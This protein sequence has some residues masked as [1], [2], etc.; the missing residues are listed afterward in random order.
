[1]VYCISDIRGD[2]DKFMEMFCKINLKRADTL[3][4]LGNIIDGKD[5]MKLLLDLMMRDNVYPIIGTHEYAALKC[6]SWLAEHPNP[7][8]LSG[9]DPDTMQKMADWISIGGQE[10][11]AQFRK[12]TDEEREMI[13]DYLSDFSLYEEVSAEGKDFVLVHAGINNFDPEKELDDYDIY[14]LI[15]ESP[16]F[17]KT[18]FENKYLV[19]GHTPTRRIYEEDNPLIDPMPEGEPSKYDKV[20]IK[21]N[22]IAINC[23]AD[24]GGRLAAVRLDDMKEFYVD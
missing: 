7:D 3:Y 18:Y 8:E 24:I 1:M 5:G 13:I 2:Y 16:D 6:L 19:S 21:N 12:L 23:G 10:T 9:I 22:H 17:S 14:E 15:S 11:I 20:F 4:L